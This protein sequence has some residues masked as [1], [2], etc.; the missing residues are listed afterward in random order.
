MC[1]FTFSL[2]SIL[3]TIVVNPPPPG[4]LLY[5]PP[6]GGEGGSDPTLVLSR[7]RMVIEIWAR[8]NSKDLDKTLSKHFRKFKIEVTC[9]VKV[10]S[11][12]KIGC[13][14]VADRRDLTRSIFR[15]KLSIC[16]PKE[17]VKVL[18]S[19]FFHISLRSRPRSG[20]KGH[21]TKTLK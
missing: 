16:T 18:A 2:S 14:Q 11:K 3:H 8:R 20:Q 10:R 12:V 5:P 13:F 15:P 1:E 19:D 21:Q 7:K 17:W 9:Q 4:L 6:P